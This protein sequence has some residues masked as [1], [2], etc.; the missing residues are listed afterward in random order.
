VP[1]V[2]ITSYDRAARQ[3]QLLRCVVPVRM[4]VPESL[5]RFTAM[6]DAY[7]LETSWAQ[8]GDPCVLVAGCPLG[9]TGVTNTLAL[10]WIGNAATG[11]AGVS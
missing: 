3:M 4:P 10:H 7:L 8:G 11:F 2:A 5:A 1:I 6:V 9:V